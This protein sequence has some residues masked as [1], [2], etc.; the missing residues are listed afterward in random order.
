[1]RAFIPT[2]GL[3][4]VLQFSDRALPPIT[5]PGHHNLL[6]G[7][8]VLIW[9]PA[10]C[11][12]SAQWQMTGTRVPSNHGQKVIPDVP[13]CLSDRLGPWLVRLPICMCLDRFVSA[14]SPPPQCALHM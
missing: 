10:R 13:G 3:I 7:Q 12:V 1:M 8:V 9:W 14:H 5:F 11:L 6:I 2:L 4:F